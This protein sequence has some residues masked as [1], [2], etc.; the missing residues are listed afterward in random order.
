VLDGTE[1]RVINDYCLAGF[2]VDY[3]PAA[4]EF[5][6]IS[7]H[8]PPLPAT[9]VAT[10]GKQIIGY[11]SDHVVP[12]QE[13]RASCQLKT[14]VEPADLNKVKSDW[15]GIYVADTDLA[16][17]F[18][19]SGWNIMVQTDCDGAVVDVDAAPT[20]YRK[21]INY[22]NNRYERQW[23]RWLDPN[24]TLTEAELA[25]GLNQVL[26][27]LKHSALTAQSPELPDQAVGD[28]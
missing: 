22:A 20:L 3:A 26:Q 6:R 7:K 1:E 17:V 8:M 18:P 25:E 10:E 4:W 13:L 15:W 24:V 21:D 2:A 11:C 27:Q 28:A 23:G 12:L 19:S 14:A 5:S 9:R 16:M